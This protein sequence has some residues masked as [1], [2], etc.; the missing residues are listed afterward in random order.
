MAKNNAK[1]P[2][3]RLFR[4]KTFVM[5]KGVDYRCGT[6]AIVQQVRNAASARGL[7]IRLTEAA[8]SVSVAVAPTPPATRTR[9]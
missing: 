6:A 1:Y 9:N 5:R 3:A 4:R 8:D 2:W 7:S